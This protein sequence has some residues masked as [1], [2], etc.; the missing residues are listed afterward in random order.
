MIIL[1]F[2]IRISR[3]KAAEELN[4]LGNKTYEGEKPKQNNLTAGLGPG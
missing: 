1:G 3:R 2:K 4:V